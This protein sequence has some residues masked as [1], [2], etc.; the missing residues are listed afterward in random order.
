[1]GR[2]RRGSPKRGQF[3][4]AS[5]AGATLTVR[6]RLS[7]RRVNWRNLIRTAGRFSTLGYAR[8]YPP[9]LSRGP[10]RHLLA[11]FLLYCNVAAVPLLRDMAAAAP[12]AASTDPSRTAALIDAC[13]PRLEQTRVSFFHLRSLPRPAFL[14]Y[15]TAATSVNTC[16]LF[17]SLRL[18][19]LL[20]GLDL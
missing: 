4:N 13:R 6:L 8:A 3:H 20:N 15:H 18:F 2:P 5:Y 10:A 12:G 11:A 9:P 7:W 1:M 16:N 17:F 14:L 19:S